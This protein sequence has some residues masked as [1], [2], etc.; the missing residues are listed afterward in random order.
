MDPLV[1]VIN[2][3]FHSCVALTTED[4]THVNNPTLTPY[5]PEW[6]QWVV[7]NIPGMNVENGQELYEYIGAWGPPRPNS[8]FY[9]TY[10]LQERKERKL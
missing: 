6:H 8:K 7:V 1:F 3:V 4:L 5:S 2:G 10:F 9:F